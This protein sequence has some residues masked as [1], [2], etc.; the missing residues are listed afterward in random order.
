MIYLIFTGMML[1]IS[2][3]DKHNSC[4]SKE[5]NYFKASNRIDLFDT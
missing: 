1:E 4:G 5:A 2:L 3:N